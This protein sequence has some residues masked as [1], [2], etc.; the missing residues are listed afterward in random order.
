MQIIRNDA[1]QYLREI[2]LTLWAYAHFPGPRFGH[3]TS[4]SVFL[5]DRE[6]PLLKMLDFIWHKLMATRFKRHQA[7]IAISPH[8]QKLLSKLY[9]MHDSISHKCTL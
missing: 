9:L 5:E 3:D 1:M 2:D 8:G 6:L 4:N 7:A